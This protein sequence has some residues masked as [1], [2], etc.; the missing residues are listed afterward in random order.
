MAQRPFAARTAGAALLLLASVPSNAQSFAV[1]S[2]ESNAADALVYADSLYLGTVAARWFLV[3]RT[4]TQLRLVPSEGDVW[5]MA[6]AAAPLDFHEADTLHMRIDF[7]YRYAF[8]TDPY[9]AL[10]L[11]ET[12][13]GRAVLGS[14]PL[15]HT[16][17][18]P[19][20]GMILFQK[21]GYELKRVAPGEAIWN[22]HEAE[23]VPLE[24]AAIRGDEW[25]RRPRGRWLNIA[26]G[27]AAL[28]S[29][30]LA[31]HFK[32]KADARYDLYAENGDPR[33]RGAFERYDRRAVAALGAMQV[34][35]GVLAI[36]LVLQ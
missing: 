36:R 10:V 19:L 26:L 30:V 15:L 5:S 4:A 13:D 22:R 29:G 32:M 2:V 11:L 6:P 28:A 21:E 34:G 24:V 20:R 1:V 35:V 25:V 3:P 33:L 8:K 17:P 16:A 27:G 9:G 7:P 31:V 23:L 18:D 14:T 12:P